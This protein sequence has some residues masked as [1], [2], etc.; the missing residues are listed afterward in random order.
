MTLMLFVMRTDSWVLSTC[1]KKKEKSD[2]ISR[3]S[4]FTYVFHRR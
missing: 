1:L 3:L 4:I 2:K